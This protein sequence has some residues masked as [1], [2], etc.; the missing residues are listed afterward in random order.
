M[1]NVIFLLISVMGISARADDAT[2]AKR[3]YNMSA[4]ACETF[5]LTNKERAKNGR[6]A[7]KYCERCFAMAQ[8]QSE[9]MFKR[10]Y[11]SHTRPSTT[12]KKGE[13]FSQRAQRFGLGWVGENI[14]QT[15]GGSAQAVKMWMN[16]PGHRRNILNKDYTSFAV[17]F[18]NGMYTQVFAKDPGRGAPEA[19]DAEELPAGDESE[20]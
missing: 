3:C 17:G 19:L 18:R 14:A 20:E 9:D 15:N 16:S 11:F 1:M 8:E 4:V 12:A 5:H 6:P 10:D 13:S 7:L 2:T